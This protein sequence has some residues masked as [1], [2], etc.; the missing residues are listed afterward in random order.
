[1]EQEYLYGLCHIPP[2]GPV[3]I[4]RLYRHFGSFR[5]VWEADERK[6]KKLEWLGEKKIQA[7]V[8]KRVQMDQVS[9]KCRR[10]EEN[11]IRILT[12]IDREYPERLR[13]FQ[14]RPPCLFVRGSLP[15][16]RRPSA[17]IVGARGCSEYGKQMAEIFAGELAD[18]GVQIISGLASGI[19]SAAHRGALGRE[20]GTYGILGCGVNICYPPENYLL[21]ERMA[22]EHGV[23]S[24]FIPDTPPLKGNFPR[25]NRL[26]SGLADAVIIIEAREKSGSL[27]TA[28][29]AL[30]QGRE[31]FAVPGRITDPLSAGTNRLIRSGAAAALGPSDVLDFFGIKCAKKLTLHKKTEKRLAKNENMVYSCLD[32]QPRHLEEIVR[33]SG[34]PVSVCLDCLL[35]LELS[36][37]AAEAGNQYY[38]RKV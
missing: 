16:D 30:D 2:L 9:E 7:L 21:Y 37:L 3:S 25:R 32:L 36:G 19:D 38:C 17:A 22:A 1:M 12:C 24:E 6:L 15:D 33:V 13:P 14:D 27:I 18:H 28:D 23:I 4:L 8:R 35:E 26:I 29:L 20:G 10:L 5:A 11:G 34:L 31:V